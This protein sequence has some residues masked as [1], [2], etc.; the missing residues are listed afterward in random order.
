MQTLSDD[1]FL[2]WADPVRQDINFNFQDINL[3]FQDINL[4]LVGRAR[5]TVQLNRG[6]DGL[7][8]LRRRQQRRC[9]GARW[10]VGGGKARSGR[11]TRLF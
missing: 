11:G 9:Q 7:S 1:Q 5:T 3:N 10:K 2:C 6:W 8:R 4:S